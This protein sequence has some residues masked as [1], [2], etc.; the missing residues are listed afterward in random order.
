MA[1]K[2][3]YN[4]SDYD[5]ELPEELIAIHPSQKRDESR[6]MVLKR[7]EETIEHTLFHRIVNYLEPGDLL[8][9]NDTKVV[10]ALL[11]GF[12]ETGGKVEILILDP[13]KKK[14]IAEREGYECIVK[15]SKRVREGAKILVGN[16]LVD[17]LKSL[18]EGRFLVAFRGVE[19]IIEFLESYGK[20][21]LPPY[22]KKSK[23][24]GAEDVERYQTVYARNPGAVAA[25]TAGFHF[26]KELL[27]ELKKMGVDSAFVT[28]HVSYGT[29]SPVKVED[30]RQHKMHK[31]WCS[32]GK[33]VL[34]Q[35]SKAKSSKKKVIAVGTTVVR[36]LE[37]VVGK[38]LL[39]DSYEGFCDFYIIPGYQ[40]KIIDGMVTNFHLPRSTLIL[41]VCAF[42]G[43][44]FILR[45]YKEAVSKRYRFYSYGD[46]MLIL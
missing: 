26:T 42:A 23:E 22:I 35:I 36:V 28:L 1:D 6:L 44:D 46:A 41:L 43:R 20:V 19:D 24:P 45:A 25:P 10:P 13:F 15:A 38:G 14:E 29:F 30:V 17:V 9:F 34:Q 21:P 39:G 32:V 31:E 4:I 3:T 2:V 33:E 7:N 8:V 11:D 37:G 12:K 40:F 16:T 5:Y 27:D 18:G